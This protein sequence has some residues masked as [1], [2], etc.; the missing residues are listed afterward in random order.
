MAEADS[1]RPEWHEALRRRAGERD[2]SLASVRRDL[3][4]LAEGGLATAPLPEAAGGQGWS[5]GP[6][7]VAQLMAV[8][9]QLGGIDL[10]LARLFEGHVN[11]IKLIGRY[12]AAAEASLVWDAVRAGQW[13]G[14]WGADDNP[15][16]TFD[17]RLLHGRKR[18][19][20]G[21]G[22][23][24]LVVVIVSEGDAPLMVLARADDEH[25][26]SLASWNV[27]GMEASRS[28]TYDFSGVPGRPF[29]QPGDYLVEPA[30]EGGVWR[31]CA[32]HLGAAEALRDAAALHVQQKGAAPTADADRLVETALACETARLWIEAAARRVEAAPRGDTGAAALAL[33]CREVTERACVE[34]MRQVDR[35]VGT[36]GHARGCVFDRMRRDLGLFL[37]QADL[38]GKWRRAADRL[39]ERGWS[40]EA[41]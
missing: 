22:L 31:Y 28:G 6:Q 24:S 12:G 13:T 16:V 8:L 38:D 39:A 10:S 29:G 3:T 21:L 14:V 26:A 4:I 33:L 40:A 5:D 34:V 41:L 18:F 9:R 30:F 20:S 17:G 36:A 27:A 11:A 1:V 35:T 15:A 32:A 23:V 37:R 7:A 25:R 2:A 19:A